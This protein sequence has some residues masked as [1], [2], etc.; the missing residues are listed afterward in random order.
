[1]LTVLQSS[2][3][4]KQ[5]IISKK[6]I[7]SIQAKIILFLIDVAIWRMSPISIIQNFCLFD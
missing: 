7:I 2:I 5:Q 6:K 1:M 4:G 3:I